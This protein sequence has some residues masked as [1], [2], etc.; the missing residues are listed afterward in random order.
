M[1]KTAQKSVINV[2]KSV[3]LVDVRLLASDLGQ[4]V[5]ATTR[6]L[7]A[8]RVP[9]IAIGTERYFNEAALEQALFAATAFGGPGLAAPASRAKRRGASSS[10]LPF[11]LPEDFPTSPVAKAALSAQQKAFQRREQATRR[12]LRGLVRQSAPDA[13]STTAT[14]APSPSHQQA[15]RRLQEG[16][17]VDG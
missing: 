2:G 16:Q 6:L 4:S 10:N 17:T 5:N 3:R 11:K 9:L 14:A 1:P 8:L 7:D 15:A 13:P 12:I